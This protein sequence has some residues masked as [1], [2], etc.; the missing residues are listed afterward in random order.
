V[1][2]VDA[3][4]I[5]MHYDVSG[6]VDA[7]VVVLANSLGTSVHM[8]DDQVGPLAASYRVLRYDMRGH[9]LTEC[10]APGDDT[11]AR[12]EVLADDVAALLDALGIERVR[13]VGLSIGGM[14]GQRFA[15]AY[16]QRVEALVLCA[17]GSRIGTADVW[18]ARIATVE[19]DGVA[20][21][22]DSVMTRWFTDATRARRH[23]VIAGFTTMLTRTP[24][25]GYAAGCRA[26]RD[27]D[28][29][30]D[31]ARIDCRTLVVSGALD[32]A[33]T[34]DMGA[35]VRDAIAGSE[36]LVLDDAAHLLCVEQPTALNRALLR[37]LEG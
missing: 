21:I 8:W 31:D 30:A 23:D 36:F 7:P 22:A 13:F 9:G 18:N 20:A 2:F 37:F 12:V 5:T 17:T 34:P 19:Q 35:E 25:A 6:P 29:R 10:S 1:A 16:P 15:A 11:K 32:P 14:V 26:V 4:G 27:A 24:V 28:L 33:T 3:A